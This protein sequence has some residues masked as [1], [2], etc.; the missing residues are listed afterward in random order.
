MMRRK[1]AMHCHC[2][3]RLQSV[4]ATVSHPLRRPPIL[5]VQTT[6]HG[7]GYN[8]TWSCVL[9]AV[10]HALR[11]TL[12][13]ARPVVASDMLS[14]ARAH[15]LLRDEEHVVEALSTHTPN[16]AFAERVGLRL[17][18]MCRQCARPTPLGHSIE[19]AVELCHRRRGSRS[20][21]RRSRM[22][23]CAAA[24]RSARMDF[25]MVRLLTRMPS[26]SSSPR[27]RSAPQSAFSDA[28]FLT[29]AMRSALA[30]SLH[31][32]RGGASSGVRT[33]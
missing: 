29:S 18:D 3:S 26:L 20:A 19:G 10:R 27:M 32:S 21:V 9:S 15:R 1:P 33:T 12:V 4:V 13:R 30:A 11:D 16:E 31:S 22:W 23:R 7:Q 14:Q 24:A 17:S 28:I 5:M 8:L 25:W 6:K 2:G